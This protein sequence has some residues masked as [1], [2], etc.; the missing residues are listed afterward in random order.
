[1][2]TPLAHVSGTLLS[3]FNAQALI[4]GYELGI[5]EAARDGA[6]ARE[7]C[8]TCALPESSGQQLLIA[9][10]TMGFLS[11]TQAG[12]ALPAD[13]RP[14]LLRDGAAYM[15]GLARHAAKFLYPLWGQA[16]AGI[17]ENRNQREK[18]FNDPRKWFEM[19][20]SD[21][22]DVADFHAFLSVLA[23]PFVESFT[24]DFDFTPYR[25]FLDI[26]SGRAALPRA[27][28]AANPQLDAAVCD[29]PEAAT[30]MRK[31][32]AQA[33]MDGRIAVYE[34]D[35]ITG[36][37]P[38]ISADLVHMGWMLHDYSA[39]TQ[40]TILSNLFA[41]LPPKATFI[42]SETPLDDD[43]SGPAFV[44][45]LSINMLVSCDGGIESTT[46]Q[47]LERFRAAGF[48]NVRAA[49]L[50]GPRVLLIGEKP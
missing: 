29:L 8:A 33:G 31:E 39:E 12:F 24:R 37:L 4:S 15:G 45:L 17:R 44:A 18:V 38:E 49:S 30:H 6:E 35:V 27:V 40:A 16:A 34:G 41:A 46:G 32:L 22:A 5:F 42:A 11:R 50:A 14:Y 7:I 25:S 43:L 13:L 3:F 28:L 10:A 23:D 48:V 9:L 47:Y 26:G 19:L 1:M 2:D 36:N 21:P 20:Y